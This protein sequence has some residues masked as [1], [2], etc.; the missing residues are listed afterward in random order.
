V[1]E[2]KRRWYQRNKESEKAKALEFYYAN[3][4][5]CNAKCRERARVRYAKVV[6]L[7]RLAIT[8]NIPDPE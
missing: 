4:E 3:R 1:L 6:E 5:A 2:S 8:P 7:R